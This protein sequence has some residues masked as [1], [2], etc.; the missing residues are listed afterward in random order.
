MSENPYEAPQVVPLKRSEAN[1]HIMSQR[2]S[3]RDVF[4]IVVR[5]IGLLSTVYG[6][7][8]LPGM[9]FPEEGFQPADYLVGN[10]PLAFMGV[11]MFFGADS[12]VSLAYGMRYLQHDDEH[13]T[14]VSSHN[15][16]G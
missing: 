15:D 3:P 2:M 5:T 8:G 6:L 4:G 9:F 11:I 7:W 10:G 12:V 1:R 14:E 13:S 16:V